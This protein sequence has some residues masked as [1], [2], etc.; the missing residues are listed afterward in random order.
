M[1]SSHDPSWDGRYALAD[2]ILLLFCF[3]FGRLN[4]FCLPCFHLT[5]PHLKIEVG[6]Y[7]VLKEYNF[8]V[9]VIF[10]MT[11]YSP[12]VLSAFCLAAAMQDVFA[13]TGPVPKASL[14]LST[15]SSLY[16]VRLTNAFM[17]IRR[18]SIFKF[19]ERTAFI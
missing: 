12:L 7:S 8:C 15:S 9:K 6:A 4:F 16:T 3:F 5:T 18:R 19:R 11:K 17:K 1:T 2:L 13:F 14:N 10:T